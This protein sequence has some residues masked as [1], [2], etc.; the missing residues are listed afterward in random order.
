MQLH[1]QAANFSLTKSIAA[2]AEGRLS[3]ALD[4]YARLVDR[5]VVMLRDLNGPKGG[6][7][8]EVDITI[9]THRGGIVVVK[10][11]QSRR[12]QCRRSRGF[13]PPDGAAKPG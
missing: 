2:H 7:D 4:Q 11:T 9:R 13:G 12:N 8:K 10:E 5:V 1:I 3:H 6:I